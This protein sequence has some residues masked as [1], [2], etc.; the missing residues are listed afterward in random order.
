MSHESSTDAGNVHEVLNRRGRA[1]ARHPAVHVCDSG[2]VLS[3]AAAVATY[4]SAVEMSEVDGFDKGD[5]VVTV[6]GGRR[7]DEY[8]LTK[9]RFAQRT[10]KV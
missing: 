7:L 10:G 5:P 6:T 8:F 3:R 1:G 2:A 9:G 4:R